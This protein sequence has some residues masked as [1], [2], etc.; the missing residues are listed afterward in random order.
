M[1]FNKTTKGKDKTTNSEGATAYK[2]TPELELYSLVCTASLQ[3][4]FYE[5][6]KAT[7]DRM[8]NLVSKVKPEFVAKL[9]IYARE[10]MY[11]RSI[12]VVL[13]VELSKIHNGDS[14]V[15][16]MTE[17]IIQRADEITEVLSYY[18]FCNGRNETK[19]LNR[20]SKQLSKGV[21]A[22]FFKFDEYQFA[23]YNRD[24]AVKI[25]DALFLTHPKP[26]NK[27]RIELF[28]KIV[29]DK[30]DIPLT[31]ETKL[32][33]AGKTKKDKKEVWE[34]LIDSKKVGYM[35]LMRN[36]RNILEANVTLKHIQIVAEY[37]SNKTAVEKSRQL[38]FRFLSAYREIQEVGNP[39]TSIF[40]TAL[41]DAVLISA[42][43]IK[44]YNYDTSILIASDVS[45]SMRDPISPRSKVESYD[46]GLLLGMLLQNRCK[47]TITGIFGDT[48]RVENLPKN[49]ILQNTMSLR[50]IGNSVGF[51]TNGYKV[52]EYLIDKNILVDK[53]MMFTDCQL[54]DSTDACWGGGDA[55]AM[56]KK[57][58]EYKKINPNCKMY[59]FD[60]AG[61]GNTP[62]KVNDN[63]VFF[64]SGWSNDIFNIL[65]ALEEGSNAIKVIESIKISE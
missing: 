26:E 60:L 9:A 1:R 24:G 51:S 48:W 21:A 13:A 47:A 52:L 63:D 6:D 64:I 31:W 30:L 8:R 45:A 5:K 38:P 55:D 39:H 11:L 46:I 50:H 37:L 4:K 61:Y 18:Q 19:K 15:S 29:D 25:R 41:E 23:K 33:E 22:S 14:L 27:E 43:N 10:Q 34:S 32:S 58:S 57:W 42:Q 44:G 16:Q 53:I 56:K 36:L 62:L 12:P 20:L 35:A 65:A 2:L 17:R 40:L 3:N 49:S 59:L 28:K 54:W 7:L